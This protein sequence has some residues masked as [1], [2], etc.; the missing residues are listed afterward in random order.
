MTDEFIAVWQ[1]VVS[2]LLIH[3]KTLALVM[4]IL[5]AAALPP[6]YQ[7][8]ALFVSFRTAE[9]KIQS[10]SIINHLSSASQDLKNSI[11]HAVYRFRSSSQTSVFSTELLAISSS[12]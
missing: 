2:K 11:Y 5:L 8:W 4:G 6:F 3:R 7:L 9:S 10:V 1:T 12:G